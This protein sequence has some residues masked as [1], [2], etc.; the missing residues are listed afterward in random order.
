MDDNSSDKKTKAPSAGKPLSE[1]QIQSKR[2]DRRSVLRSVGLVG[3]GAGAMG[4]TA[5]V[6]YGI[7][8]VDN[9][10]IT[11]PIGAGRGAPLSYRSGI[12]DRDWGGNITDP[13]GRGRGAPYYF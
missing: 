2:V 10:N 4:V 5:C 13:V 3:L 11:D 7:T 8:D 1:D 9:G 12:T 6:P